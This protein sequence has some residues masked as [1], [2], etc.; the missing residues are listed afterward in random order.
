MTTA[1]AQG[2]ETSG[3]EQPAGER[4]ARRLLR[5]LPGAV[6]A[7]VTVAALLAH[8]TP[9]RDVALFAAYVALALTLPGALLW[10][11]LTRLRLPVAVDLAA[12]TAV[13]YAL[14]CFTYM[15]ARAAGQPRLA[16]LGPALTV[17]A[18]AAVPRL[19]RHWRSGHRPRVPLPHGLAIAAGFCFLVV[20]SAL[21]VFRGHGLTPPANLGPYVD[22]PFHL[23]L[24]GELRH[25]MPPTIPE[26]AGQP[27]SYH[28]FVYSDMA[29]ASWATGIEPETLLY[30]LSVLPMLAVFTV[31]VP[32]VGHLVTRSWT[33]GALALA[34]TYLLAPPDPYAWSPG[35]FA[36]GP[37]TP[38]LAWLSPTQTFGAAV[39][40]ALAVLVAVLLRD[41]GR[42]LLVPVALLLALVAGAKATYLPLLL[43]GVCLLAAVDW[44]RT[45]RVDRD[46]LLLGGLTLATLAFAQFVLFGGAAQGVRVWPLF[47]AIKMAARWPTRAAIDGLP[48]A[49][50]GVCAAFLLAWAAIWA[51]AFGP[52]RRPGSGPDRALTLFLGVGLA[53][54]GVVLLLGQPGLGQLYFLTAARPY[55][56]IVAVAG[57]V[58]ALRPAPPRLRPV[59]AVAAGAAGAGVLALVRAAG[60]P[61]PPRLDA[62][63]GAGF[64][65]AFVLPFVP[66]AL[67]TGG[68]ALALAL[69]RVPWRR[70]ALLW[71]VTG[72]SVPSAIAT[73]RAD[74]TPAGLRPQEIPAE[75][76]AAMRWLRAHSDPADLVA[77]NA[78]CRPGA[79]RCDSRHFWISAYA[80][81]RVLVESWSYTARNMAALED[82]NRQPMTGL[83]FW[84]AGLLAANDAVFT[85]PTERDVS[86]LK[87]RYGVRWLV[88]DRGARVRVS[89]RLDAYAV[90]RYSDG[91]VTV[92][93][94]V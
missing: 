61:A 93:E 22:M 77:T 55:L 5:L 1:I 8:G 16:V 87:E 13:G 60:D 89:P 76:V 34:A 29:A 2:A 30:R 81:R 83:P 91:P 4:S 84:D 75:G 63:G 19:R 38:A 78:H 17:V 12:G 64:G 88:A 21:T 80:E 37:P 39:F 3:D 72:L 33:A 11:A 24:V 66:L 68:L 62:P 69:R 18:F 70:A 45:R 49:A 35:A 36:F 41:G 10:R 86:V 82:I 94:I 26:V 7:L 47:T 58:A 56:W 9:G 79:R 14:E 50:A 73:V 43:A 6:A 52:R 71:L 74:L 59:L 67:L 27:L 90:R 32:A 85:A 20:S 54:L 48:W 51:G 65:W 28:W 40:S 31:L 57:L 23:A 46:L 92:Y 44:L 42:R 15:A 53:S 25:H